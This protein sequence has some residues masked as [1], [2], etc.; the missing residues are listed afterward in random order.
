M[1]YTY[2]KYPVF[3]FNLKIFPLNIYIIYLSEDIK[4]VFESNKPHEINN[5]YNI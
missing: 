2:F 5:E 1:I 4:M 3:H